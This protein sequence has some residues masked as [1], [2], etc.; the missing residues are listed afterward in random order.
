MHLFRELKGNRKAFSK[1]LQGN[2][3]P[4]FA[5]TY[6]LAKQFLV[7]ENLFLKMEVI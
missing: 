1:Y 2:E 6:Y 5:T 4:A 3:L 7:E